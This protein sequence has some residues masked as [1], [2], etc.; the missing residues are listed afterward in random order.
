MWQPAG[1][2][3]KSCSISRARPRRLDAGERP[4]AQV[5]AELGVLVADEV[6]HG[7]AR[8][9]VG[10]AQA[11][12]ELLEEDGRALGRPQEQDVSTSGTST[13]SL[14]RSTVKR[15]FTLAFAERAS[16]R[17]GPSASSAT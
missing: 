6:E 1:R 12:A 17:G 16:Q 9:A 5:E 4:V 13:P 15:T 8:L 11:A 10:E 2:V 3:G 14:N 7:Q